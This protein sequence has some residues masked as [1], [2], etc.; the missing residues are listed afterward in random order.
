MSGWRPERRPEG[1]F[2]VHVELYP[3]VTSERA[4][5]GVF[6]TVKLHRFNV[7]TVIV[8]SKDTG[9]SDSGPGVL[10]GTPDDDLVGRE[11]PLLDYLAQQALVASAGPLR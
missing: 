1:V 10:A 2:G 6:S 7:K 4:V 8:Y 5:V 9:I 3:V 11:L